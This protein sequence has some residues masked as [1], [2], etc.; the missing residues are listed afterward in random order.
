MKMTLVLCLFLGLFSSMAETTAQETKLNLNI[1]SGTVKDVIEEIEQLTDYSFMYD[2]NIFDVNRQISVS[3]R[4]STV[5]EVLDRVVDNENL[6]YEI[7]N[8]FIVISAKTPSVTQQ[9]IQK[10]SGT[11]T[12]EKGEILPGVTVIIKGTTNGTITDFD[13][14]YTLSTIPSDA[15][16]VFSFIGMKTQEVPV[17][18]KSQ[19]NVTMQEESIGLDEVVAIGY[20][21]MKKSDLTG[22][23]SNVSS[24]NFNK[25][26]QMAAQQL[27]QGKV[28]GVNISLNS[29]KPGGATTVRVRGGTSISASND[30]LYVIDG[31]PISTTAGVSSA[32]IR[33]TGTDFFDQEPTNPLMTLNPNDIESINVLK[34]ASATAI[35]GSRGANGVIM[36]TTKKGKAGKAQVTYDVS[37]SLAN[38]AN[39]LDVLTADEYRKEVIALGYEEG[40]H[41]NDLGASTNWQDLIYRT[42]LSH[43]HYLSLSGGDESTS[44]RVSLGYGDQEG[45]M[46]GSKLEKA[47]ARV[48]ILH[49]ALDGKLKFDL[50]MNYGQN[51]ANQAP[52]SNTV[53]SEA[54]SSMNYEAYVFNPTYPVR[55][56]NG[57]YYH[58]LPYRINPVSFSTDI[59]DERTNRK[60]LGNLAATYQIIDPLSV[61][62]NIGYTNQGIN[63]NSYI[64]KENPL[65]EGYG[66]YVSVQKLEDYSKLFESFLSYKDDFGKIGID[67]I[68]GYSY[69]YFFNEGLRNTASGFLS[70]EFRW[71]SLQAAS[72]LESATSFAES[73]TLISMYGRLN[74][75][76][77]DRFLVT[78]TLRRDGSSRFGSGNKWGLFPSGAVSWRLTQED[79]FNSS[80]ISD[81]KLRASYGV[82]GNQEIGNYQSL[83]SLSASSSGYIVGGNRLT[84][85]LPSRYANPNLKW[86]QTSQWDFGVNFGLFDQ[87][88]YGSI[89]YYYKKTS[90]LLLS[91]AVP[92]PSI[93]STQ[94]ANVGSVENKGLEFELGA[95]IVDRD[96]FAWDADFNLSLNRNKVLSLSNDS[97]SGEDVLSAP[98]QGAGLA[99][100]FAQLITEGKPLGSFYGKVFKGIE[101]GVEVFE[102]E[103]DFI[104]SAQPDFTFGLSNNFNYKNWGLVINLRGSVGNDV[105]NLTANNLGYLINLPGRNALK[106]AVDSGISKNEAKQYSSRWI[107][108]GSFL[109]LDN[110][111]LSYNFDLHNTFLSN[112]RVYVSGQN[113]FVIT[114]YSGL[115][116]EVNS[117]VSGTGVA[118][119]GIDYLSYPKAR[120]FSLGATISF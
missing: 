16:L 85:V 68:A 97:W 119:L 94:I 91:V 30:P 4:N 115:D 3:E 111:T 70:D 116:P 48:N 93:V 107:E 12:N 64:S 88:L 20:G 43:D 34:D 66:G 59:T 69:Q 36:I 72:N 28:S 77:D 96:D 118:P 60:F 73:N 9:T 17:A 81:L 95:H 71:Y 108:D 21:T 18:G 44:Y 58:V 102:D 98:I 11:V 2:N 49:E 114:G 31:V 37:T 90:D 1:Q 79:F 103:S 56:A 101:N 46:L 47:N 52:V 54:G 89:D 61:K 26:S 99:G 87:R 100:G 40:I 57:D 120:T 74:L 75:N 83:S 112:A 33:G 113:L 19:I 38:V 45:I 7:V 105:Y 53:G 10:V 104:G 86:E 14:N 106:S 39:T 15:T 63:R 82:T 67:A 25:G 24:D 76:I 13:G 5:S 32:N 29:G 55:D 22:S 35:Y 51:T 92:S 65:G 84:V 8:R 50:R 42:A 80:T 62:V 41:Y 78:G 6:K 117:E 110:V 109:R 27:V 23:V